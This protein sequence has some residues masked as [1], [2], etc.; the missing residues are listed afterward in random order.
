MEC[1]N[2]ISLLEFHDILSNVLDD[3]CNIITG[4]MRLSIIRSFPILWV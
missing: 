3:A 1:S 4:I 2:S